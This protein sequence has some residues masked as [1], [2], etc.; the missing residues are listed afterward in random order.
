[1]ML[2]LVGK[3]EWVSHPDF[4]A[5]T[6]TQDSPSFNQQTT[7]TDHTQRIPESGRVADGP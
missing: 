2:K 4:S 5:G 3:Q 6:T 1:M 7:E